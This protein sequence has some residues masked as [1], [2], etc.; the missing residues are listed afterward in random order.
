MTGV[1]L[2]G[3]FSSRM[4]RDKASLP[5]LETDFIH[6]ILNQLALFCDE[7]IVVDNNRLNLNDPRVKTVP[8][9]IP[10]RGPLSGIH[11]G[12]TSASSDH[13]FVTA[14]DMP[15]I[16]VPA[17][18]HLCSQA[19]GWDVVVPVAGSHC[20]PLFACYSKTCIPVIENLLTQDR[21][22]VSDLLQLVRCKKILV[23]ELLKFD[24]SRNFLRNINSPD[25]Y[26]FA[27]NELKNQ[28]DS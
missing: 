14:C 20:E 23:E 5:W 9:I 1:V 2:A 18:L 7:L 11:A 16:S 15:Y 3:G 6:V 13:V 17:A 21:R 8:D 24:P 26:D 28:S 4:G 10:Q 19:P 27:L 22:K 25:E 12:L